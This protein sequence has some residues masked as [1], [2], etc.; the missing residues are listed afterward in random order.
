MSTAENWCYIPYY[1]P[2][3]WATDHA[4]HHILFYLKFLGCTHCF[5][6]SPQEPL[7]RTDTEFCSIQ[8]LLTHPR[9]WQNQS[10]ACD[11]LTRSIKYPSCLLMLSSCAFSRMSDN[12]LGKFPVW[13]LSSIGEMHLP[14]SLLLKDI[15]AIAQ[16]S[17][18]APWNPHRKPTE[19]N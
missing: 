10:G 4:Q 6:Q 2:S 13:F 12:S 8:W 16:P 7:A 18:E 5:S 9:H 17:L 11:T 1:P 14:K 15:L 3:P 19:A